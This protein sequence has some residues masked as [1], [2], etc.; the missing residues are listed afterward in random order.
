MSRFIY[1]AYGSNMLAAR[2]IARCSCARPIGPAYATGFAMAFSKL[3]VDGSGKAALVERPGAIVHG[4]AFELDIAS[5]VLLDRIE[6]PGYVRQDDF[7]IKLQRRGVAEEGFEAVTVSASTYHACRHLD[8]L[9]PYDWYRD[10]ILA[11]ALENRLPERYFAR[12]RTVCVRP[13]PD[14]DRPTAREARALLRQWDQHR[15]AWGVGRLGFEG[16]EPSASERV[17]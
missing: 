10:L 16:R 5:R 7:E 2:L 17:R 1:F 9:V 6:G 15:S 8:G 3:S 13:D 4:V 14:F 11:G 12:L